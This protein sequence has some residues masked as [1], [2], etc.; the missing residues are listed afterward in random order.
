MKG[1]KLGGGCP[2]GKHY[3]VGFRNSVK[4]LPLREPE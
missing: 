3:F 2:H 4:V 1:R